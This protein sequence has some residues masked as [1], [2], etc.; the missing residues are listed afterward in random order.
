MPSWQYSDF[1]HANLACCHLE[2]SS[3]ESTSSQ[4]TTKRRNR[5]RTARTALW[6]VSSPRTCRFPSRIV[7]RAPGASSERPVAFPPDVALPHAHAHAH[8]RVCARARARE[9]IAKDIF[10]WRD[11]RKDGRKEYRLIGLIRFQLFQLL[12]LLKLVYSSLRRR[13]QSRV[14]LARA[15]AR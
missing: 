15:C 1:Q 5:A 11:G 7:K 13:R 3:L 12:N 14:S 8:M 10:F 9:A 2:H 6:R 4:K